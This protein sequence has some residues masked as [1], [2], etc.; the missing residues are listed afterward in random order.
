MKT[1]EKMLLENK[2]WAAEQ[3]MDDPQYFDRLSKC[4]RRN[5]YG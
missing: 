1:Y 3:L 2:A 5:F 4:R